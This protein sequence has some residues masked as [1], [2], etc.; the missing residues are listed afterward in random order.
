MQLSAHIKFS[1]V[2]KLP[3]TPKVF[4][5]TSGYDPDRIAPVPFGIGRYNEKRKNMYVSPLYKNERNVHMGVDFWVPAGTPVFSFYEGNIL[6]FRD[7]DNAGDY[8]PTIVTG[9]LLDDMPLY[10]LYGHLSRE[11]LEGLREGQPIRKGE[12]IGEVG[13]EHENGGWIPHLH[14]QLCRDKPEEP[15]MPGVVSEKELKRALEIYPDPQL[16]LGKLY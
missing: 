4:D 6:C 15:D 8:G 16:V 1:P 9:H 2:I 14:F 5:F 7:N 10:A 11:S 13:T 3:G 12:K